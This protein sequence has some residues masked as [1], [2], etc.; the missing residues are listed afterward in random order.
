MSLSLCRKKESDVHEGRFSIPFSRVVERLIFD[1]RDNLA[2]SD[3]G[4]GLGNISVKLLS[5]A[6]GCCCLS[7]F[8]GYQPPF[9]MDYFRFER[10]L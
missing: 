1:F 2:Q 4:L 8:S 6:V 3:L 7:I 5:T 9:L 10:E